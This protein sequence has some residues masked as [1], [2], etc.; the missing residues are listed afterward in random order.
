MNSAVMFRT[1]TAAAVL[2]LIGSRAAYADDFVFVKN[3]K[4]DTAQV[5]K[6]DVKGFYTGNKKTWKNGTDVEIVLNAG[7]SEEIKWVA[8]KVMGVGEEVLMSRIKQEVFKGTMKKPTTVSSASE[9]FAAVK[10]SDG[11]IC[12]VS[13]D[14]AKSL[15][16]GVA[17]LPLSG[18]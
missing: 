8:E 7:G 17:L 14:A 16:G 18:G 6:S 4:N 13:S 3:A 11:G 12:A 10:K 15:P 9:C 1:I 5:S 2:A